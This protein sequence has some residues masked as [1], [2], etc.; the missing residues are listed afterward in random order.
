MKRL[1]LPFS[2]IYK[3]VTRLRNHLYDIGVRRSF[4]FDGLMT[5]GVGNLSMGGTGKTPVTEYLI[6]LLK[7]DFSVASLSRG[8]GR[9]TKGLR[10]LSND[11]SA[12]TA[13]DEP[14]QLYRKFGKEIN[15]V[16]SE[17]RIL[18]IPTLL[19]E[20]SHPDVVI[21]DDAFQHRR[22]RTDLNILL[23]KFEAPFFN[24]FLFPAGWLRESRTGARR[25][26]VLLVTKCPSSLDSAQMILV[27]EKARKY[28]GNIPVFF[29][30]YRY[31]NP[32]PF[33]NQSSIS[34]NI[35]L[36]T[37]IAQSSLLLNHC[38]QDFNVLQHF[39]FRDHHEYSVEDIRQII[40]AISGRACSLL[41]TEKD[42]IRLTTFSSNQLISAQPWFY[43]PV[44][45]EFLENGSE[46]D[47]LIIDKVK[48][49]LN[50]NE[51]V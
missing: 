16:V 41:T 11:D 31:S 6:R 49:K 22:I 5:V 35:I 24:D 48:N 15:V 19:N 2:L 47:R 12:A 29:T 45:V 27:T 30:R 36:I 44:E 23:T 28:T 26:D 40:Q 20:D 38:R 37:G 21:L 43:L 14:V 34:K 8:Y 9:K 4:H 50:T 42:M 51:N 7:S 18:A 1:L 32:V 39:R 10:L 17:D 46:F 25:A 13:G 33:G 3:A